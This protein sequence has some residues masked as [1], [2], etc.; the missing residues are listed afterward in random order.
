MHNNHVWHLF[1][2]IHTWLLK[3]Q[4]LQ[5][6]QLYSFAW[7]CFLFLVKLTF[8]PVLQDD[9]IG[10]Q[11]TAAEQPKTEADEGVFAVHVPVRLPWIKCLQCD[12]VDCSLVGQC[13]SVCPV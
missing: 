6:A 5:M 8:A 10:Y 3:Y 12:A 13:F 2:A 7:F 1:K 9:V 4:R 11:W